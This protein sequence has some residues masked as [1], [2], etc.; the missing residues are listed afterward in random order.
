MPGDNNNLNLPAKVRALFTTFKGI[1]EGS[2]KQAKSEWTDYATKVPSSSTSNTYAWLGQSAQFR[3]WIG[4]RVVQAIAKFD[5]SIKNEDYEMTIEV[6]KNQVKDDQIGLLTPMVQDMADSAAGHPGEMVFSALYDGDVNECYDGKAFFAVDHPLTFNENGTPVAG[7][8]TFSNLIL[9][10]TGEPGAKWVLCANN[11]AV[12]PVL[13]QEREAPSFVS[14]TALDDETVFRRKVFT[15]G[16]DKR[17][18]VGYTLPQF[19]VMSRE[20]LTRAN[21]AK[22]FKMLE[23]MAGDKGKALGITPT[24][25]LVDPELREAAE[26]ILMT[27][28]TDGGKSNT[29]YK[30]VALTV[31]SHFA[32][33][34]T[35]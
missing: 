31:T 4:D 1:F 28:K 5:Y 25:L 7:G 23:K 27:E 22:A 29:Y 13:Y 21:F 30:R 6:L 26:D 32:P 20:P 15:F 19:A 11:K 33:N 8:P 35:Q 17:D 16:I 3:K 34:T 2:L 14:K 10:K 9:P 18:A 12:K 24:H